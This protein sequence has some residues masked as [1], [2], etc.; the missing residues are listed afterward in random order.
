MISAK[1]NK[2]FNVRA[3][4]DRP[5]EPTFNQGFPRLRAPLSA[6]GVVTDIVMVA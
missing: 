4:R 2:R 3:W 5:E 6:V 1:I